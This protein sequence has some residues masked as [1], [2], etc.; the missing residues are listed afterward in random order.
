MQARQGSITQTCK[1][2]SATRRRLTASADNF[3]HEHHHGIVHRAA[4]DTP[5]QHVR[6]IVTGVKLIGAAIDQITSS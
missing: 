4:I 5:P 1:P 3:L 6:L 2:P